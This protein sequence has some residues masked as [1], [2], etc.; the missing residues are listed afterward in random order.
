[1]SMPAASLIRLSVQVKFLRSL[2]DTEGAGITLFDGLH[3]IEIRAG[4]GGAGG[5]QSRNGV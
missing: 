3:C 5:R 1:M 4:D 2:K